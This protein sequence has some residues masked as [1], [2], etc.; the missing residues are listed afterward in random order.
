MKD[1]PKLNHFRPQK[2][3]QRLGRKVNITDYDKQVKENSGE[4]RV[5]QQPQPRWCSRRAAQSFKTARADRS[6]CAATLPFHAVDLGHGAVRLRPTPVPAVVIIWRT[7]YVRR[8]FERASITC[9][10]IQCKRRT[11]TAF[12]LTNAIGFETPDLKRRM[13]NSRNPT[14]HAL[15]ALIDPLANY[16]HAS[17]RWSMRLVTKN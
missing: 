1:T 14:Q 6:Y 9:V 12:Y 8:H 13:R 7:Q 16:Q 4:H 3:T 15:P 5:G 10:V 11:T 2:G 17:K